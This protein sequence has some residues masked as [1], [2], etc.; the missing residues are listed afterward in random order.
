MIEKEMIHNILMDDD[1]EFRDGLTEKKL[2]EERILRRS[3]Y[4][5]TQPRRDQY[6]VGN[7]CHQPPSKGRRKLL[8]SD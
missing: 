1:Q 2:H 5:W 8:R 4:G 6:G 3:S 7:P